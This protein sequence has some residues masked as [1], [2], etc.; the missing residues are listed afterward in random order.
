MRV[1]EA[2]LASRVLKGNRGGGRGGARGWELGDWY[3]WRGCRRLDM[4]Y[5]RANRVVEG[6]REGKKRKE[7][8]REEG[9]IETAT[10]I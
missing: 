10:G 3:E 1:A 5:S 4:V 7:G 6:G 8:G 2:L 9:K